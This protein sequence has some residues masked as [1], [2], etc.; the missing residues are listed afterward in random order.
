MKHI[1]EVLVSGAW[2]NPATLR[3]LLEEA[4]E[5]DCH[6]DRFIFYHDLRAYCC[7][8]TGCHKAMELCEGEEEKEVF[9]RGMENAS[10]RMLAFLDNRIIEF[11]RDC[12]PL[13]KR[14]RQASEENRI[15]AEGFPGKDFRTALRVLEKAVADNTDYITYLSQTETSRQMPE[16]YLGEQRRTQIENAALSRV[17]FYLQTIL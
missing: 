14:I 11:E 10:V 3:R 5:K 16:I 12:L 1:R 4:Y 9:Y 13:E 15:D 2:A 8:I 6:R 17:I 7:T